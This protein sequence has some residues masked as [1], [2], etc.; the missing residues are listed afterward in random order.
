MIL[1]PL[2]RPI[3][4]LIVLGVLCFPMPTRASIADDI[5][6]KQRQIEELQR[7]ID[8]YQQQ[9][10]EV[11]QQSKTLQG[12]IAKLNAQIGQINAQIKQLNTSID[13]T[14]L[15][16]GV[17]V[18][19]IT[20]AERKVALHQE[21]LSEYIRSTNS[22]DQESLSE[23]ILRNNAFS[24]FYDYVH[25]IQ[26]TQDKLRQ[27][28]AD[29]RAL[30]NELG[31]KREELEGKKNQL[32]K[33]RSL[34]AL[35]QRELA[36]AKGEKSTVLKVTQ[37]KEAKYQ[38]LIKKTKQDLDRIKEQI[39][40]LQ[41][42]GITVEDAVKYA[43]LAALGAGIRPAFLLALLEVESR[44]GQNVGTGNWQDDMVQC[45]V[46]LSKL[47]TTAAR[48]DA[49]LKRAETEKNA[50]IAITSSLGVDPN[51]VKVSKEPSYGCGGAMGPAQFIPSTWLSYAPAVIAQT[52][53]ST[54]SPWNTQDAFTAAAIKLARGGASSKTKAGEVAAA[55][56]YIGGSPNCSQAICISYANTI[57]QK[58]AV[59]EQ[60]L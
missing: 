36:S 27:S 25:Q 59:I 53:R 10:Q 43:E 55:K 37:G 3:V 34:T 58:A 5:I 19:G 28:I 47:A 49:L 7:Q 51:T 33:M 40:Y 50:F 48:R 57:Q 38:E 9:Q 14:G 45:Y 13:Q 15:E 52:G 16:I 24:Q 6:A 30:Q 8:V 42:N 22:T 21:A 4:V 12:E 18:S 23:I 31:D 56:A 44:L 17:T 26:V 11:G 41:K 54:A 20:E 1:R 2:W 60:N 39:F 35:Q 29:I 46:R 32:E